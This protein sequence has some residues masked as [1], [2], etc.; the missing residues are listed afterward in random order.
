MNPTTPGGHADPLRAA[1]EAYEA[2][3]QL[4]RANIAVIGNAGVGKSTLISAIFGFNIAEAGVGRAVTREITYC[5]YPTGAVGF[6]DT[7]GIEWASRRRRS[8]KAFARR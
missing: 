5:E 6:F 7:R 2:A 4:G 8:S 3:A 1:T